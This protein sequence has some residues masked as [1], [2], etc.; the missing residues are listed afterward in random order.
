MKGLY[1]A[2]VVALM[3]VTA[4]A[5][6]FAADPSEEIQPAPAAIGADV[7]ATYLGPQPSWVQRE[8]VGEYQTLKAG[9]VDVEKGTIRRADDGPDGSEYDLCGISVPMQRRRSS[10]ARW[11]M[12]SGRGQ[13]NRAAPLCRSALYV[14]IP[15]QSSG[16][17]SASVRLSGIVT[18]AS[19]GASMYCSYPPS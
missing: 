12:W 10:A 11:C 15:A 5:S 9:K 18:R 19:T 4:A 2:S 14:V 7:P 6:T 1:S 16:A 8:F 3:L 17:A 13:T